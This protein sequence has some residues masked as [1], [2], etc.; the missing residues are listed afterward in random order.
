MRWRLRKPHSRAHSPAAI[1]IGRQVSNCQPSPGNRNR[2]AS[3]SGTST[4]AV[5]TRC[6][7][8]ERAAPAPAT[9]RLAG[10]PTGLMQRIAW[11]RFT[12]ELFAGTTEA[13]LA[14]AIGIDRATQRLR[15]EVR[16]EFVGE[17]EL[18]V[19]KLPEQEIA[20][21]LLP[22]STDEQVRLGRVVHGQIRR[23]M[24]LAKTARWL[25]LIACHAVDRLQD[26]PAPA[27][28][29]CD[30]QGKPV[31]GCRQHFR[32]GNHPVQSWF[33]TG[34]IADDFQ[35]DAILVQLG[36]FLLQRDHE[37]LHQERNL[38]LRS[39]P[40]L[41]AEREQ[42]QIPHALRCTGLGHRAHGFEAALV[43]GHPR[44]EAAFRPAPVAVHDNGDVARYGANLGYCD[45]RALV[46]A[47][48]QTAIRSAS[49]AARA[50][51]ISA[52]KRSV[53][54]WISS[55]ARR[56]SSSEIALVLSNSFNPLLA[57][58]RTLRTATRAFSASPRTTFVRSRRR[59]S[60]RA[61]IGTRISSPIDDGLSPRPD[62]RMAFSIT[63][64][65]FFSHGVT[66]IVRA[67]SSD[68]LATWP[69][70]VGLP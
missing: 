57:S 41:A 22:A 38:V 43:P 33:E 8:K 12:R 68:R 29:R 23:E 7:S 35:S 5:C 55:C 54:F 26:I 47:E 10:I 60:V 4:M 1:A 52:M 3:S 45:G 61:G 44:Q 42:C 49:L 30:R 70:G 28:V 66:L 25:G 36:D 40:I 20:D 13:A 16:P 32:F 11:H 67:S 34:Q 27:I 24:C 9:T 46:H 21:A 63:G 56:S 37:Q 15:V 69:S 19:G 31:V 62:S 2:P 6:F 50:L 65:I 18:G 58:R 14:V 48:C 39:P 17:I 51:S 53:S 59:S 64:T